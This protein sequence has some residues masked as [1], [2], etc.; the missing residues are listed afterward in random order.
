[1]V[2]F[3]AKFPE[4]LGNDLYISGESYAGIYVPYLAWQIYQNNGYYDM[5]HFGT[6]MNLRGFLVGN[7]VTDFMIDVEP[8]FPP[9]VYNFNIILKDLYDQFNSLDCLFTFNDVIPYDNSPECIATWAEIEI[10]TNRLNW[11][12]L[13]RPT[14]DSTL[15]L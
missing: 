4:F 15:L 14:Y 13:Y 11:Y 3:Y 10:L 2:S 8:A 5:H 6:Y 1:M 12:D 7:G 9:T